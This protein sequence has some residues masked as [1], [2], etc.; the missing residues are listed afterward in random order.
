MTAP[1]T[2]PQT[3][4]DWIGGDPEV[5]RRIRASQPEVLSPV[6][7]EDVAIAPLPPEGD[8]PGGL[9]FAPAE[10]T[11]TPLVY[12]HGGGFITGSPETH[13][14]VTAWIA[15]L[16]RA[17]AVSIRYRLAPEHPLPAQ[18]QD[19]A[20]AIRRQLARHPSLRL[21]GDSAGAMVALWGHA[22][23]TPEE[24]ARIEDAVLLYPG[25]LPTG[26]APATLDEEG[27]LGPR[28]LAS[29]HRRL[30]PTNLS[31][32]NPA[33]DPMAPG[34]PLPRAVSVLGAGA[35][36]VLNQSE[37][38]ARLPGVRLTV[39]EGQAHGFL[40]ALPA[41]AAAAPLRAALG[42]AP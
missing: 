28:S 13:R 31:P 25:G 20:A 14:I 18:A 9:A 7:P 10:A 4:P 40:A 42:I 36:P 41:E 35:D 19:A 30:D 37:A 38:L 17:P 24:K 23:L 27:G 3:V 2:V 32:G 22:A 6:L 5:L 39:A 11:G 12:F 29:Y 33:Y 26:P 16:T 21:M 8:C 15:H 34:F 1:E